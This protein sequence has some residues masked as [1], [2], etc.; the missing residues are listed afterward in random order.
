M[1]SKLDEIINE[2]ESDSIYLFKNQKELFK[3]EYNQLIIDLIN[4]IPQIIFS[5]SNEKMSDLKE[6]V[7]YWSDQMEKIV[8]ISENGNDVFAMAD[9]LYFEMR[10]NL[11]LFKEVIM[12][13]GVVV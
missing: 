3:E 11:I 7:K 1:I 13:R 5:Y 4:I 8:F 10:A 12:D 2:L 9:A 6:D